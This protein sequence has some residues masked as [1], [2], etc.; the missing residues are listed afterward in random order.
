MTARA[1]RALGAEQSIGRIAPGL[2][3]DLIAVEVGAQAHQ[4]PNHNLVSKLAYSGSSRDVQHVWVNGIQVVQSQQLV[5]NRARLV[6]E[7]MRKTQ[8]VW[9]TRVEKVGA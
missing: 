8:R 2:K 3:A 1:A 4:L 5:G 6:A 7:I 9:Q